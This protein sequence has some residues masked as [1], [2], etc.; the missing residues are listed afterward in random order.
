MVVEPASAEQLRELN[1]LCDELD[2]Y[3]RAA[4]GEDWSDAIT[5]DPKTF[6]RLLKAESLAERELK[7]YFK[8]FA[9]ERVIGLVDWTQY[10]A[11]FA[12]LP[13]K[14]V[15]GAQFDINVDIDA[16]ER[17]KQTVITIILNL[18]FDGV[19]IGTD[20]ASAI[21][22]IPVEYQSIV[23]VAE[24]QARKKGAKLAKNITK[25]TRD[26][27]RNSVANSLAK[28]ESSD[29]AKANLQSVI[30]SP[31]RAEII[32][33]TE[34]VNAYGDGIHNFGEQTNATG[35]ALT[36][37]LDDRTSPTCQ[38]LYQKY[39]DEKKAIPLDKDFSW[40]GGTSSAPGFHPRCRTGMF[41][42]Y[43]D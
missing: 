6:K 36:V 23:D 35:K 5:R 15:K 21:Y 10:D 19:A 4:D 20:A 17:E 13:P 12:K 14:A 42:I 40:S 18:L 11:E 9:E 32:A 24:R 7:A 22:N 33:R 27:I 41:L 39:G 2:I 25:T 34:S 38:E 37:V 8:L 1:T 31:V 26:T 43:G 30:N 29:I 16:L 28:G 3:I